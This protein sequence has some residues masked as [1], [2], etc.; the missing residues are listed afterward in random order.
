M[1]K[2]EM[3]QSLFD[4]RRDLENRLMDM[5]PG[6]DP[7]KVQQYRDL[8]RKRDQVFMTINQA[9]ATQFKEVVNPQ[10]DKLLK[11]LGA[12]TASLAGLASTFDTVNDVVATTDRILQ[13]ALK[14]I[15]AVA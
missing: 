11:D 1:I 4:T 5:T 10:V 2:Q 7:V 6:Q 8:S 15:A 9:I 12:D 14:V 3:L 13:V